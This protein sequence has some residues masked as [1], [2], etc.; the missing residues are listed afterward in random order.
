MIDLKKNYSKVIELI[1]TNFLIIVTVS[2]II[3]FFTYRRIALLIVY[4][5]NVI[6]WLQFALLFL[7]GIY[8]MKIVR[9]YGTFYNSISLRNAFILFF[10]LSM[11]LAFEEISWGQ[12]IFSISTPEFIKQINVQNEIT[13]HNINV[14]QRFRHWLLIFYGFSGL[15]LIY[16]KGRKSQILH[17]ITPPSY[18]YIG[19]SIALISGLFVEI[20]TIYKSIYQGEYGSDTIRST[21]G[22][23]SEIGEFCVATTAFAFAS[24]KYYKIKYSKLSR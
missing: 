9:N 15:F 3:L 1:V 16:F 5:D 11:L 2:W 19:F 17:F 6:Q 13:L 8:C 21:A 10:F 18:F 12:R 20:A 14:F 24:F 7:A 23:F 4:E 22:R